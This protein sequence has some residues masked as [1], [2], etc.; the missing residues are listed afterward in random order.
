MKVLVTGG[1]GF[2][3]S[4][5]AE[6]FANY[7][8]EVWILDRVPPHAEMLSRIEAVR[9]DLLDLELLTEAF[10]NKDVV[11]HLAGVGDVYLAASEPFTAAAH[12]A[13]G[14][15][16]VAEAALRSGV[17][18]LVYASTWEVYGKPQH[19]PVDESHPCRPDH[20]YNITKY[21]GELLALSYDRLH[22]LPTLAL[23]LG[24][25]Y[26]LRMRRNSVFSLFIS[27]AAA[28]HPIIVS[29][30]GAQTRQFTHARDI[31]EGFRLAAGAPVRGT[32]MNLVADESISIR[33]LA[34]LVAERFP[35]EIRFGPTRPGDIHPAII[36]SSRARELL[37]WVPRTNFRKGLFEIIDH[38][39]HTACAPADELTVGLNGAEAAHA[40]AVL[41]AG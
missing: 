14:T 7:G 9:G 18:K 17:G 3:G 19:Q 41:T 27:Q 39:L 38:S 10:R 5:V 2:L 32:V 30:S 23:R 12:N 1:A 36:D 31:A 13:V 16:N 24:T 33:H 21:A 29:G 15:A 26:G 40:A 6:E 35:T 22:N 4:H 37:G 25:A 28:G 34:D 20:P 11:C 8:H